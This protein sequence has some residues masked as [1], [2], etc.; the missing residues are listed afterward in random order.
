MFTDA[1]EQVLKAEAKMRTSG[2]SSDAAAALDSDKFAVLVG[3]ASM[4]GI[5]E[6]R[7][8]ADASKLLQELVLPLR[9]A[10]GPDLLQETGRLVLR[11]RTM[12]AK[13]A[14]ATNICL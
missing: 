10:A 11:S 4:R 8:G 14:S 6:E 5:M 13:K 9:G 3:F 12:F 1:K 7:K 2:R